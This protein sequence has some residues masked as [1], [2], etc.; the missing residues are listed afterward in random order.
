MDF[1]VQNA[2]DKKDIMGIEAGLES[3]A[4]I[5]VVGSGG[6][7]NN[8]VHWLYHKGVSGAEIIAMNTDTQHL[9]A[10]DADVK[11]LLG[12]EITSGLG[13]GGYPDVGANAARESA[14]EIKEGLRGTDMLFICAG[15]G[16]G[17]GTGSAPEIAKIARDMGS[18]VIGTV[19]MPFK[20]ERAR[21]E[22]AEFGLSQLRQ[23]CDTVIVVDNNRLVELAGNLPVE[24]AFAVANELVSTMIKAIVETI[25]LPSLVNLDF[26]DVK[27]IMSQ[28]GVAAIGVG[29]SDTE[30][31]V[32]EAV[33]KALMNPLLDVSYKGADGA[34]IHITGGPDLTLE[35]VNTAGELITENLD[36]DANVI[37]GARITDDMKGK[38]RVM[39]IVTGVRSP[40]ILGALDYK[41]PSIQAEQ[42]SEDLG[43]RMI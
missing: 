35:E 27:A 31:R 12:K 19:T 21:I 41:K 34:L 23:V 38:I 2:L 15:L 6:C 20:I 22:K 17:T 8:M 16:G 5:K 40:Y 25:A 33:N 28:G 43:I 39:A 36:Q 1:I 42:V 10:R 30:R 26:A 11:I 3:Q 18:I 7:G 13:A 4:T 32:E 29:E 14:N 37:W 9:D 24:K